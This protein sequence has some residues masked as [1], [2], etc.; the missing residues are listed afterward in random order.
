MAL[1]TDDV[2]GAIPK[3]IIL[4]WASKE[5]KLPKGWAFCDGK[6]GRPNLDGF[7]LRGTGNPGGV[8]TTGGA[9]SQNHSH[10]VG[11]SGQPSGNGFQGE[12][13][14]CQIG[15]TSDVTINTIP[16][17]YAVQYIIKL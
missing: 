14:D 5:T 8:G 7:F 9:P 17:F 10:T 13:D 3:G 16:P 4:P 11:K 6:D 12:G 2:M 15:A 1:Q